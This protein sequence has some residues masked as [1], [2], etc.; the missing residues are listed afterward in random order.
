MSKITGHCRRKV[1]WPALS[2][3][4]VWWCAH[5][6]PGCFGV[7][8]GGSFAPRTCLR[9]DRV[10]RVRSGCSL[11][12]L[13]ER[14]GKVP[15]PPTGST[16][17]ADDAIRERFRRRIRRLQLGVAFF[18]LVLVYAEWETRSESWPPRLI[19]AAMNLL[20]QFVMIQSI[21]RMQTQ[22]KQEASGQ[23]Q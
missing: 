12:H 15:S 2:L 18:A 11:G 1:S 20:I 8:Q 14:K 7:G 5:H 19:G 22:L 10:R 17:V 23:R 6:N 3:A 13:A 16:V 21:R 9:D 4:R